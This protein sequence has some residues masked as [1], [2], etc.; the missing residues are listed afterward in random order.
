MLSIDQDEDCFTGL[1]N[2]DNYTAIGIGPGIGLA[3]P[4]GEAFKH[5][6]QSGM[7]LVIDADAVNILGENKTWLAFLPPGSILTPH[8]KEF[9][10]LGGKT[11]DD[12]QR[13]L[14]QRDLSQKYS[15]Y[16]ILK[17][18]YTAITSPNGE[19]F[20]NTSGNPGMATAGSGDVLTGII[21]GLVAQHYPPLEACLLGVYLHGL[22]GDLAAEI[23]GQEALTASDI[24][25][26][27]GN[28]FQS[29]HGE[30]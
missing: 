4:T 22:A 24:I 2:L 12:F 1:P 9:E 21:T 3:K 13:N 23:T 26:N 10:R 16:I 11:S 15:C 25:N 18:A 8:P 28:A 19:C 30:L 27:I 5:L 6:I 29:L 7:P 17:G 20:F 14:L